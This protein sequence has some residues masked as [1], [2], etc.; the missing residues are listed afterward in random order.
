MHIHVFKNASLC[1]Q[2]AAA[3]ITAQVL[4]KPDAVLGLATG[5]TPIPTYQHLIRQ[6]QDGVVDFSS[7]RVFNL[8]EYAGVAA[9]HPCS[10]HFFMAEQL[11]DHI[12]IQRGNTAIPNGTAPDLHAE[13]QRYDAAIRAA[14]GIDLQILG[15]GRNGHIGFNEPDSRFVYGCHPV[16]LTQSTIEANRRFFASEEEVPRMAISMGV[17]SILEARRIVLIATGAD[18]ADAVAAAVT[19]DID[20]QV[21][22]SILRTHPQVIFLLDEAA[23]EKL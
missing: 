6:Y 2:A 5:S 20:P 15:I 3:L 11:F 17:G 14:G 8:D 18:K 4:Q 1:G 23:A 9:D 22:A 7:V 10:Y 13:G 19:G 16:K 12:N 21:P